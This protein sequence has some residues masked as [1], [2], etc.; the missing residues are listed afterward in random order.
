MK[1]YLQSRDIFIN[2]TKNNSIK[3][4]NPINDF[5]K[6]YYNIELDNT[7][8]K[9]NNLKEL[10]QHFF[11]NNPDVINFMVASFKDFFEPL[12]KVWLKKTIDFL[13]EKENID[14]KQKHQISNFIYYMFYATYVY[15]PYFLNK[16]KQTPILKTKLDFVSLY[17][18]ISFS[19]MFDE[20]INFNK[21]I[22]EYSK[23][24]TCL[25]DEI[26]LNEFLDEKINYDSLSFKEFWKQ[27]NSDF[28]IVFNML[29]QNV[30]Q[31]DKMSKELVDIKELKD[32]VLNNTEINQDYID[33]IKLITD[34]EELTD[35]FFYNP[36][37]LKT[38]LQKK[39][40][41]KQYDKKEI[42]LLINSNINE[43]QKKFEKWKNSANLTNIVGD[44]NQIRKELFEKF[45]S[46]LQ[47]RID[48]KTNKDSISELWLNLLLQKK[49]TKLQQKQLYQKIISN[50]ID[51]Q[52]YKDILE[53]LPNKK[54]WN[55]INE[56]EEIIFEIL[57][58]KKE[59]KVKVANKT[60]QN[61]IN[62]AFK[63]TTKIV[64]DIDTTKTTI[65]WEKEEFEKIGNKFN[66]C[67]KDVQYKDSLE[68]KYLLTISCENQ[69]KN[70]LKQDIQDLEKNN[71][72]VWI[73]FYW[74]GDISDPI[75]NLCY[76]AEVHP[77]SQYINTIEIRGMSNSEVSP[78]QKKFVE[79]FNRVFINQI[80]QEYLETK[81]YINN[82]KDEII[83]DKN[84]KENHQPTFSK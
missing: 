21:N 41:N 62:K 30:Y 64:K 67:F 56:K 18:N 54:N 49:I 39:L 74:E 69:E 16:E 46:I 7:T 59:M 33:T 55:T 1:K 70:V 38:L 57:N 20:F 9:F 6:K 13:I 12:K 50:T 3:H 29:M 4:N 65:C 53:N 48:F 10:S 15:V 23:N 51:Y 58:D 72:K 35:F 63:N 73:G 47:K 84:I 24:N 44:T 2:E 76:K 19:K 71:K 42:D 81:N 37:F 52:E 83:D 8:T 79:N 31:K 40:N 14:L 32:I 66:N 36:H 75:P 60:F 27:T 11:E 17:E 77:Q 45:N 61:I 28:A 34:N 5:F 68:E 82:L 22:L 26:L 25:L 78:S 43:Y 80:H